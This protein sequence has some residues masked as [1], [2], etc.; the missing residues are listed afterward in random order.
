MSCGL[1]EAQESGMLACYALFANA[2]CIYNVT[3]SSM[4]TVY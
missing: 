2:S 1:S 3:I 4:D